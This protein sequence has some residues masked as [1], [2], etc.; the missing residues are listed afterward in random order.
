M[1]KRKFARIAA[2][3]TT[4]VVT[5]ALIGSVVAMTGAYFTDTHSGGAVNATE[6]NVAVKINGSTGNAP[7]IN[8]THL[9]PGV[10]QTTSVNVQNTG[11][12]NEDI[13]I[14][15]DNGNGGWSA[16]N[17]M[18]AY[19]I[20]TIDGTIYDNLNNRYA[21]GT[22]SSGQ[23]ISTN[24]ASGCYNVPRPAQ[25]KFLPHYIKVAAGLTPTASHPFDITFGIHAC[26]TGPNIDGVGAFD[27]GYGTLNFSVVAFE[28]GIAPTDP[29]NGAG[30]IVPLTLPYT[31][32]VAGWDGTF[33]DR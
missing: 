12:G 8:F 17:A 25:I 33:Q 9:M 22:D 10:P 26:T 32:T 6:G 20:F 1:P 14:V 29:Y 28:A 19:G 5:V 23:V 2:L 13:Y 3:V 4:A 7:V 27:S 24:P 15:F 11:S 30:K 31:P 18:G 16:V 21:W